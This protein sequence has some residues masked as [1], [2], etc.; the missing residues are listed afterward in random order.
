MSHPLTIAE[1]R[2]LVA[3]REIRPSE[4]LAGFAERIERFEPILLSLITPTLEAARE[5]ARE[6]DA[7][8]SRGRTGSLTG[9]PYSLKDVI[10][11]RG[12]RT[13]GHSRSRSDQ[14]PAA[15]ADVA[16]RL[17]A[18][19]GLLIGK[20]ATWEFA[21]GGPSWDI[22]QEPA[23]NP[24]N[25]A[26]DPSGSSSG[27]AAGVAAG[28][29]AGSIGSDTG[30]SIR[31]PASACGIV[32]LKPTN[33]LVSVQGIIPNSF[34]LD[35]VGPM[36]WTAEDV[37]IL[38]EVVTAGRPNGGYPYSARLSGSLKGLRVG[39]P[40]AWIDKE[41]PPSPKVRAAF[42]DALSVLIDLGAELRGVELPPLQVF[43]D[44]KKVIAAV[45]LFATHGPALRR[46]PELL[47]HSFR[48]RIS[49]GAFVTAEEY[50]NAQRWR[51]ELAESM[52]LAFDTIDVLVT[53]TGE[54][55]GR[56][57]PKAPEGLFDWRG[58]HAA[59]NVTGNPAL[60]TRMG[61]TDDGLPLSLQIV[62]RP[63]DES[64]ILKVAHQY[65]LSTP[66]RDR[67]PD[68]LRPAGASV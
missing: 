43:E 38:L 30:G 41:A 21:H 56:L 12:I 52:A 19:D 47:G 22:L 10:E 62:G 2:T 46:A 34:S 32:G 61:F 33:G 50:L 16:R 18:A 64:L 28:L 14:V 6:A 15:D 49:A 53:P 39:L 45:E 17:G 3:A 51:R 58:F 37:A 11:I 57:E 5:R 4:V 9:V 24:W 54:P 48:V 60:A 20:A 36:A 13:T 59:F 29:C 63:F 26:F 66:W 67:R 68:L 65:E 40:T 42:E 27:S 1:I 55:A 23:R 44:T 35:C 7:A 31:G 8:Q 25:V